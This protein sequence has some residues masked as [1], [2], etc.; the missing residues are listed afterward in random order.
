M[1]QSLGWKFL[2]SI[3]K[4]SPMKQEGHCQGLWKR[5]LGTVAPRKYSSFAGSWGIKRGKENASWSIMVLSRQSAL[6]SAKQLLSY[7]PGHTPAS[8]WSKYYWCKLLLREVKGNCPSSHSRLVMKMRLEQK[9]FSPQYSHFLIVFG[10][11]V[12]RT[13]LLVEHMSTYHKKAAFSLFTHS[14]WSDMLW[15]KK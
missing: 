11:P 5:K 1:I 12:A 14:Q 8:L 13:A 2:N 10:L 15:P 7:I 9:S 3:S 4:I 6:D